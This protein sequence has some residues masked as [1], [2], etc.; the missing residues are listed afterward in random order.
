MQSIVIFCVV[1]FF[2]LVL[3]FPWAA[4]FSI[5]AGYLFGLMSLL[6]VVPTFT[7]AAA[8]AFLIARYVLGTYVQEHWG[9]YLR[10]FNTE[11]ERYGGWYLLVV[12]ILPIFPYF[13]IN[14]VAALTPISLRAFCAATFFGIIPPTALFVFAGTKLAFITSISD[15]ISWP[16][17]G[18]FILLAIVLVIPMLYQRFFAR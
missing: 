12:R 4:L 14:S 3:S 16:V 9:V 7:L 5:A 8:G 10:V 11:M 1:C 18:V 13:L 15:I 6:F 2:S 17:L